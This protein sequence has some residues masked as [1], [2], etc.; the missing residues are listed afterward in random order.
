MKFFLYKKF[1]HIFQIARKAVGH[2]ILLK[3]KKPLFLNIL[4]A[5]S[6]TYSLGSQSKNISSKLLNNE[7]VDNIYIKNN[8]MRTF[9]NRCTSPNTQSLSTNSL[10]ALTNINEAHNIALIKA[11]LLEPDAHLN[12]GYNENSTELDISLC[13]EKDIKIIINE[14]L[15][16]RA[17]SLGSKS[18]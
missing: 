5:G 3:V 7:K 13:S 4:L 18:W 6:R 8:R 12:N 16:K 2:H 11:V 10:K 15:R 17:H 1:I 9:N 14:D